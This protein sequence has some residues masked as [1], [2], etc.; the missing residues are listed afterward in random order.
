MIVR[1]CLRT[2]ECVKQTNLSCWVCLICH[3]KLNPSIKEVASIMCQR[4][5]IN[6]A[7]KT[8]VYKRFIDTIRL[9]FLDDEQT[10]VNSP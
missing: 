6:L 1:L 3:R 2:N 4:N 5:V 10:K 8:S 7:T 9:S